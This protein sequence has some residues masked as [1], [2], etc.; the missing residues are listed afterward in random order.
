MKG[1]DLLERAL[2]KFKERGLEEVRRVEE[3][4]RR[5]GVEEEFIVESGVEVRKERTDRGDVSE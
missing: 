3:R 2:K 4:K 1:G 5:R